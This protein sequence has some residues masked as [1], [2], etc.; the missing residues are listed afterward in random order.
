MSDRHSEL[1]AKI[2]AQSWQAFPPPLDLHEKD[3]ETVAQTLLETGAGSL[4]LVA[5]TNDFVK[6]LSCRFRFSSGISAQRPPRR[7]V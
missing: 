2:L 1:I 4:A 7:S 3:L 5:T 6:R